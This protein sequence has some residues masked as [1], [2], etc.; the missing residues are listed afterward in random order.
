MLFDSR[1]RRAIATAA[2]TTVLPLLAAVMP[3][4]ANA[5]EL[6]FG[7]PRHDVVTIDPA[8]DSLEPNPNPT[9]ANGDITSAFVHFRKGRMV[10]RVDFA[11]LTP[12]PNQLFEYTGA[13]LTSK[14]QAFAF[15]VST[16][17]GTYAGH[18]MLL[19]GNGKPACE[20][21]HRLDWQRDFARVVIPLA[22]LDH[23][24]WVR[25]GFGAITFAFDAELL[26]T[27]KLQAGSLLAH[28]DHASH[29][30]RDDLGLTPRI[31]VP[32]HGWTA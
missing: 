30:D 2:A 28:I 18:D 20:V 9:H 4:S 21:G 8:S 25:L 13:V 12:R 23:P 27:G 32:R 26:A 19:R 10:V 7:D 17:P 6:R 1:R 14:R 11:E 24:R 3:S 15:D 16:S 22:C 31:H 29:D 5:Q